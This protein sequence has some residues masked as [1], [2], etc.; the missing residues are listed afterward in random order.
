MFKLYVILYIH[1]NEE[2]MNENINL[3]DTNITDNCSTSLDTPYIINEELI[4]DEATAT[5][6]LN[7]NITLQIKNLYLKG[8]NITSIQEKLGI[9]PNTWDSWVWRNTQGFRD[10]YNRL[11]IEKLINM[12]EQVSTEIMTEAHKDKDGK[13]NERILSIKQKESEFLRETLGKDTYS[14]KL[15][16]DTN[17]VGKITYEWNDTTDNKNT[18]PAETVGTQV[19]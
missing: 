13:L 14:K 8:Y 16:N 17:M 15:I 12:A 7:H 11:K 19:T 1:M 18:V 9:K 6:R 2:N 5:M 4:E 10:M 3:E